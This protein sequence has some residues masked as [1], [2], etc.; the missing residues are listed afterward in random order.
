MTGVGLNSD[1][2]REDS[3]KE[4]ENSNHLQEAGPVGPGYCQLQRLNA[5]KKSRR[6]LRF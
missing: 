5:K 6:P 4:Y 1:E 2:D 3:E